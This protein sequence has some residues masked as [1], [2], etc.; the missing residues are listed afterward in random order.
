MT[1]SN[2]YC[3]ACGRNVRIRIMETETG[4]ITV[5]CPNCQ[6][7]HYRF[8]EK[9]VITADRWKSSWPTV[10]WGYTTITASSTVTWTGTAA[11]DFL[12]DSWQNT[13]STSW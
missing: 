10:T 2:I 7:E 13:D 11:A 1:V 5:K 9:G 8:V 4:N 12:A 6:H 3:H